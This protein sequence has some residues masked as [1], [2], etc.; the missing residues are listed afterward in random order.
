MSVKTE[1]ETNIIIIF[2]ESGSME[3][4]GKE[5]VQSLNAFIEVQ[6]KSD[7]NCVYTLVTFSDYHKTVF[8]HINIKDIKEMEYRDY[9]PNGCTALNDAI[10]ETFSKELERGTKDVICLIITDGEENASKKYRVKDVR[11]IINLATKAYNWDIKFIGANI[12][13][14]K[15]GSNIG[16][17]S[18]SCYQFNQEEYGN[19]TNITRSIS[20]DINNLKVNIPPKRVY[21][22]KDKCPPPLSPLKKRQS[23]YR[24]NNISPIK[25]NLSPNTRVKSC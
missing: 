24:D 19:L 13:S 21:S 14:I 12:D 8:D 23:V 4:M 6:K 3:Y 2:D 15:E 18:N 5:P 1:K 25:F 17:R 9:I 10:Y 16:L 20:A 22:N 11:K 7:N